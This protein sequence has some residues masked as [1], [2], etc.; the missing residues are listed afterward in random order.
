MQAVFAQAEINSSLIYV[1]IVNLIFFVL[2]SFKLYST[3][4]NSIGKI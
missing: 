2:E 3:C 1:H 4:Q